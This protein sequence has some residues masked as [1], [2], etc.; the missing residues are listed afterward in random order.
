VLCNNAPANFSNL[1][2]Y[3]DLGGTYFSGDCDNDGVC[4]IEEILAGDEEDG[5]SNGRPDSCDATSCAADLNCDGVVNAA[6]LTILLLQWN[7]D[8]PLADINGDGIVNAADVTSLLL[9]W[10]P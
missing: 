7:Q 9:A 5:N 2:C 3:A 6:D 1:A 4:D 10:T 8:G